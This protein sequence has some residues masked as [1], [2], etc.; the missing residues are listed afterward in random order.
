M[1]VTLAQAFIPIAQ[2]RLTSTLV[3]EAAVLFQGSTGNNF[4]SLERL[5]W[6]QL[7]LLLV[8]ALLSSVF[9]YA[10]Q[11]F[12]Q[13]ATLYFDEWM[14]AKVNRLSLTYF[15]NHSSYDQL[16]RTAFSLQL[17]GI[18]IVFTCLMMVQS[19]ITVIGFMIVLYQFHWLLS[20]GMLLLVIPMLWSYLYESKAKFKLIVHQTPDER[21]SSYI[22]NLLKSREAA[23]EI[24]VFETAPYLIT[25]WKTIA[26]RNTKRILALERKTISITYAVQLVTLTLLSGML[27][28]S[29]HT[30][31]NGGLEIG[32]Y[33]ALAQ[34]LFSTQALVQSLA[35][36]Y[37]RIHQD[38]LHTNELID[39]VNL[40]EE[41]DQ[42]GE[43]AFPTPIQHGIVVDNVSFHY[44]GANGPALDGISFTIHAG[45]KIAIVGD[46]GAGKSTLAKLLLGLYQPRSGDISVDGIHYSQLHGTDFRSHVSAI[47][48]DFV[49]YPFPVW[50]NIG[51]G[52]VSELHNRSR[53]Q[54]SSKQA[55]TLS[56]INKLPQN[57]DTVLGVH[58]DGGHELSYG[59]WQRIA[60]N[61]AF[62]RDFEM[63][64][65]DEPTAS[66]DPMTE[67]SIFENIMTL[68][69]DKTAVFITHRLGSCRF[70]DRIIVLK[71]GRLVENGDHNTLMG[72]NGEY[73]AMFRKQAS[74]YTK[75]WAE[76]TVGS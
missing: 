40:P 74:W 73:A 69:N 59:Q 30:G 64:V 28:F 22:S 45:E 27:L 48:Q 3:N 66:L 13:R 47:F 39:F 5:V 8:G 61:R 70:A 58:F 14:S 11:Y 19:F 12:N 18:G 54:F 53:L 16:Q 55:N 34:A 50:E 26:W 6:L 35:Q 46:N 49:Q 23:K 41:N 31:V 52:Q 38:L 29:L 15:D 2:L 25:K 67:S 4:Q 76:Q 42:N 51:L 10:Q 43:I 37:S 20:L 75:E 24:R 7:A 71:D 60:L 68:T 72:L 65:L 57:W 63:I 9:N 17:Q 56:F 1:C 32:G 44:D 21:M 33:V 62:F 36:S